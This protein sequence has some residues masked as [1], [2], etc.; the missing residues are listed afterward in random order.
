MST[1]GRKHVGPARTEA[2]V[3]DYLLFCDAVLGLAGHEVRDEQTREVA[4][5]VARGEISG[6]EAAKLVIDGFRTEHEL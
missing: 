5:R 6:D 3:E 2:E 4:R 1:K